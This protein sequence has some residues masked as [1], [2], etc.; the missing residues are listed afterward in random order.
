MSLGTPKRMKMASRCPATEQ[1][2]RLTPKGL[3]ARSLFTWCRAPGEE[4]FSTEY[5]DAFLQ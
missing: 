3:V 4:G 5:R 1:K 2:D